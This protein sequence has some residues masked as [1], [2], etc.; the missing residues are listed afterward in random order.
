MV[1]FQ[2]FLQFFLCAIFGIGLIFKEKLFFNKTNIR[3]EVLAS[4]LMDPGIVL[5]A[6]LDL[7]LERQSVSKTMEGI[8]N[9]FNLLTVY[10]YFA[11]LPRF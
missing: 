11:N 4:S 8:L 9:E 2:Y 6:I 3:R 5:G 10:F 1:L 7:R